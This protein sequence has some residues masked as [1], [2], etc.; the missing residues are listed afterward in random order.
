MH[1]KLVKMASPKKIKIL[2]CWTVCSEKSNE[3][4]GHFQG[5]SNIL[6]CSMWM[7]SLFEYICLF[8]KSYERDTYKH[9]IGSSRRRRLR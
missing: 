7:V 1:S 4:Y 5:K 2:N 9:S 6:P 3:I 8:M